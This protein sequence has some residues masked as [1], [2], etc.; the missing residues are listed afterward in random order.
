[1]TSRSGHASGAVDAYRARYGIR[2]PV[3]Q[4]D[5]T[6]VFWRKEQ[7]VEVAGS[8]VIRDVAPYVGA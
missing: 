1:M 3:Q 7:D 8:P 6:G 5:W 2:E 4:I